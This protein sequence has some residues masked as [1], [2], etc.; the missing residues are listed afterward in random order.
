[1]EKPL[2]PA[3]SAVLRRW[4][5]VVLA[6]AAAV[7]LLVRFLAFPTSTDS[8]AWANTVGAVLDNLL[9]AVVTSIAIGLSYVLLLPSPEAERV[10][11]LPAKSIS[12]ALESAARGCTRWSVRA[13]TASYFARKILPV[14]KDNALHSGGSIQIRIQ[15][16]DPENDAAVKAYA[17]YRSNKPGAS[18]AWSEQRVR[19][20]IY[21][22]ILAVAVCRNEAPRLDIEVGFSPDFWVLSLDLSDD[23]AF[24]TGQNKGD[25]C[26]VVRQESDFFNGWRDDFDAG[27]LM[28]RVVKPS[29]PSMRM[30]DFKRPSAATLNE[31]RSLFASVGLTAVGDLELREIAAYMRRDHNYA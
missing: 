30:S 28:C 2:H 8:P 14:L 17:Q 7:I 29:M 25:P 9:A 16:L 12:G 10:E 15:L 26:L 24:I 6:L 27:F 4:F 13:R 3:R 19:T 22:T 11:I 31:I 20:E 1:M 5:F 21:S 23:S 18:A